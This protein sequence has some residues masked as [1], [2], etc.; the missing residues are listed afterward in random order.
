MRANSVEAVDAAVAHGGGGMLN[1]DWGDNGHLQY[2]P[3][4][5]PG[6]AYGAAVVVVRGERTATSISPPRSRP[7]A[8]TTRPACSAR[9]SS[10]LGDLYLGITPQMINVSTL[11][12][13][14]YWPHL[15]AG[16][17]PLKGVKAEEYAAVEDRLAD[18]PRRAR[19][20]RSRVARTARSC[21]TSCATRSRSSR[22]CAT[23][24]APARGRRD[25]RRASRRRER[26]AARGSA[27]PGDRR[28]RAALARAQPARRAAGLTGVA[29]TISWTATRPARS[30]S[31]GT[32]SA[33]LDLAR[34]VRGRG[35]REVARS[36]ARRRAARCGTPRA[37]A[38]A[39]SCVSFIALRHG[40]ARLG[41]GPLRQRDQLAGS[42][43]CSATEP[44]YSSVSSAIS[45]SSRSD[46]TPASVCRCSSTPTGASDPEL[47]VVL[48][49]ARGS[50]RRTTRSVL[51]SHRI[52]AGL[53]AHRASLRSRSRGGPDPARVS[54]WRSRP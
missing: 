9:R 25:A 10:T 38:S 51:A 5:E 3:I 53:A 41:L 13:P 27:P 47:V 26:A 50:R 21:S 18:V 39:G 20:A 37:S 45:S 23:T 15:V 8:T 54:T 4:S 17:W 30:T 48:A 52:R 46:S 7:T 42:T 31:P 33:P 32:A 1:T 11:V 12:L 29:A 34:H 22:S 19:D 49:R 6:L 43:A 24:G 16:R 36:G 28:A 14:L 2:L 44:M 40:A 35:L